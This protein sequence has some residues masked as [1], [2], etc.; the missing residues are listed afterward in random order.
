MQKTTTR[1]SSRERGN[2]SEVEKTAVQLDKDFVEYVKW[3]VK[4]FDVY[5]DISPEEFIMSCVQN[6]VNLDR[7]ETRMNVLSFGADDFGFDGYKGAIPVS[8]V[9]T[10]LRA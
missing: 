6:L 10:R 3:H 1:L 5:G 9:L 2:V 7:D 8:E 4:A